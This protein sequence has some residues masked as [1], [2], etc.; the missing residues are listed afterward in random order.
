[1]PPHIA[2]PLWRFCRANLAFFTLV[3]AP[4]AQQDDP[5]SWDRLLGARGIALELDV[6]AE[7]SRPF[8]GGIDQDHTERAL[9][10]AGLGLDL[11]RL[12]GMDGWS[13]YVEG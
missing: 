8:S 4:A 1:M 13:G 5:W 7:S 10:R 3:G 9:I 11:E 2:P 12:V 6:I